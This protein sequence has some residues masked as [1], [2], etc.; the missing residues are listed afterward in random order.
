MDLKAIKVK[1]QIVSVS[2]S[3]ILN[4]IYFYWIPSFDL[5][6]GRGSIGNYHIR[7]LVEQCFDS[8]IIKFDF[9]GGG[10]DYKFKWT[11]DFYNNYRLSS[12]NNHF[13]RYKDLAYVRIRPLIKK[14]K[15]NS[16]ILSMFWKNLSKILDK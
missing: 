4:N 13:I 11:K 2:I 5:T 7:A 15:D 6:F 3:I 14:T 16:R 9:M 12:Y 8:D 10:E 1:D